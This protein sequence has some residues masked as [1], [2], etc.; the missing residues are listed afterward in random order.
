MKALVIILVIVALALYLFFSGRALWR[1]GKGLAASG[2]K[3][4][5]GAQEAFDKVPPRPADPAI[6]PPFELARRQQA[7]GDL[8]RVHE[9]RR[10]RRAGRLARA[11]N[12]WATVDSTTFPR[13]NRREAQA[14]WE[15]RKAERP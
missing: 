10:M 11:N 15:A 12:R 4:A 1:S 9:E 5:E 8:R 3:L 14:Q 2:Q 7:L 13:M 6:E